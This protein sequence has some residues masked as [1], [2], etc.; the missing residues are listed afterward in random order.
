MD[1]GTIDATSSESG[2]L[3][4]VSEKK[5]TAPSVDLLLVFLFP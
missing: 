2:I 5:I 4:H 3:K 1:T